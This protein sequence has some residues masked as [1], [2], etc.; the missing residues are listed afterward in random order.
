MPFSNTNYA[1]DGENCSWGSYAL[2]SQGQTLYGYNNIVYPANTRVKDDYD[3]TTPV[4]YAIAPD[5][6]MQDGFMYIDASEMPGD[7]CSVSFQGDFCSSDVLICSGWISG[8]NQ[9]N[10]PTENYTGDKRCP[11]GITLTMKG[12]D[13]DGSTETIYRYCPGQCYEVTSP[14]VKITDILDE[15]NQVIDQIITRYVE[16]QQFYFEFSTDKKYK[17]YWMEVNNNCVSSNGGDFMLD[18]IEVYTIVPEVKPDINTPLC[19]SLDDEGK[20]VTEMRLLKL[21]INYNKLVSSRKFETSGDKTEKLLF[22][23]CIL[24]AK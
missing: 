5:K 2:A 14:Y 7:I 21:K 15:D 23:R 9:Q 6:G 18:N 4:G 8:A 3:Q 13:D 19:V 16:W 10:W 20:P 11:G 17:R 12:E 24:W 22:H 1:F